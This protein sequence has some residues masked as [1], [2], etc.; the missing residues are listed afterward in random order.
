MILTH[1]FEKIRKYARKKKGLEKGAVETFDKRIYL[2]L[3]YN[4]IKKETDYN[5][6]YT[7]IEELKKMIEKG[8]SI[9]E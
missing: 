5:A 2:H 9:D 4:P 7:Q 6:F 1:T 8:I 3:Y